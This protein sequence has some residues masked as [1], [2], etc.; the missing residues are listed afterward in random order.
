MIRFGFIDPF[1]ENFPTFIK[2]VLRGD[3]ALEKK[4]RLLSV[5]PSLAQKSRSR[6]I[7]YHFRRLSLSHRRSLPETRKS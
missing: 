7:Q 1:L 6:Q 2:K 5:P 4:F 3:S